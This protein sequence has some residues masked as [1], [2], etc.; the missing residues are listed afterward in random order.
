MKSYDVE[1]DPIRCGGHWLF[2]DGTLLPIVAGGDGDEEPTV[3]PD[4]IERP[5]DLA[6]LSIA[7]LRELHTRA[8]ARVEALRA[9]SATGDITLAQ[10]QE[11]RSLVTMGNEIVAAVADA[12]DPGDMPALVEPPAAPAPVA[13]AE[14]QAPQAPLVAVADAIVADAV[15]SVEPVV[16]PAP[17]GVDA[18]QLAHAAAAGASLGLADLAGAPAAPTPAAPRNRAPFVASVTVPNVSPQGGEVDYP[19]IQQIVE[20]Q[21]NQTRMAIRAKQFDSLDKEARVASISFRDPLPDGQELSHLNSAAANTALIHATPMPATPHGEPPSRTAAICG[22]ADIIREIPNCIGH[23]RPIR[24]IFRQV[25][26]QHAAFQFLPS[27]GLASVE[28]GVVLW[29]D[30]DQAL[31]D[32]SDPSTWKPCVPLVC[33]T[34]ETTELKRIPSCLTVEVLQSFSTPEQVANWVDTIGAQTERVAEG[35]LLDTIDEKSSAYT[36]STG[37]YGAIPT[38]YSV[39]ARML[40]AAADLNR[41]LDVSSY[42][43]IVEAGLDDFLGLDE[44]SKQFSTESQLGRLTS[45][46]G[47]G[48]VETADPAF[49]AGSLAMDSFLPLNPAGD[50]AVEL[51]D[52]PTTWKFRLLDPRDWFFFSPDEFAFAM[53]RDPQLMRQN[54]IQWFGELFEGLEKHGCAPSFTFDLE[55]CFNGSRAGGAEILTCD[56]GSAG[57]ALGASSRPKKANLKADIE[58]QLAKRG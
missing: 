44:I 39:I 4:R 55:L 18:A 36:V 10:A 51:G 54:R 20:A 46:L 42:V 26:S 6:A 35:A 19:E 45:E 43:L 47:I 22:P 30:A 24:G 11:L 8:A 21:L 32:E 7:A 23:G 48:W 40:G 33:G 16:E 41:Q 37:F 31:V 38:L 28:A 5:A 34:P 52:I 17:A 27:I 53:A 13:V 2:P 50:P 29:N 49:T 12:G 57:L 3:D 1:P 56:G 58:K 9:L 15:A 14:P 25:P